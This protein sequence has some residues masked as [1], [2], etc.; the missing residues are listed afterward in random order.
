MENGSG[1]PMLGNGPLRMTFSDSVSVVIPT[2]NRPAMV[3]AAVRSALAQTHPPHEVIVVIDGPD[4]AGTEQTL[5]A[6]ADGRVWVLALPSNVGGGEARNLGVRTA[7][8]KWVAFL[9]DDDLWQPEKL[10]VQLAFAR[11]FSEAGTLVLSCPVLARGPDWEEVWPREPYR[12]GRSMGEYLFCRRGWRYGSALLQ[13]STLLAPRTLLLRIP[14]DPELRK[15]QDWDLLLRLAADS[16]VSVHSVGPAPL[17][18]FHVEGERSSVGRAR[19]WR[20]S[21]DWARKRRGLLSRRAFAGFLA[22]ECAPQVEGESWRERA[23]VLSVLLREGRPR[24]EDLARAVLFLFVPQQARRAL[25]QYARRLK[26]CFR[27]LQASAGKVKPS[28]SSRGSS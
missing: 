17:V 16:F 23:A 25:R 21:L 15:H 7:T 27:P 22:T 3:V 26:A 28:L 12:P 18:I 9:D 2:R 5:S 11:T 6:L 19:N 1:K 24:L 10:A 4:D 8:G 20:Y 13:T 14:F